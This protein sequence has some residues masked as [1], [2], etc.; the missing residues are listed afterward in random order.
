MPAPL[1]LDTSKPNWR[2]QAPRI[3]RCNSCNERVLWC[4]FIVEEKEVWR[5]YN[6]S[7]GFLHFKTCPQRHAFRTAKPKLEDPKPK[8]KPKPKPATLFDM[9]TY[10][11]D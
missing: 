3:G 9:T 8:P 4:S 1:Q 6:A 11:V 5:P 7:D 2:S 10:G